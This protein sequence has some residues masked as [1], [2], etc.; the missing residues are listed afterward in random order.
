MYKTNV[1]DKVNAFECQKCNLT[2]GDRTSYV[3]HH[4]SYHEMSAKRCRTGKFGEPVIGIDGKFECPICRKTFEEKPQYFGHVGSHA[5]YEGLTPEAFLDKATSRR[6]TNDSSALTFGDQTSYAQHHLSYHEM[7]AKRCRTGKFGEPVVRID[8]KFECPICRKTFEEKPQ[9]FGHVGS[10]ARY[11]GLTP[12]AFLD[13]ATS[14]RATNDSSAEISFSL[15][16]LTESHGQNKVSYGEAGFQHHNHSN[17][18][19]ENN[20]TITEF[21]SRNYSDNFIRPNKTW[22]R[23]EVGPSFNDAPSV[24]RYTNFTGHADVTVPERAS[25][26]NN[27]SVSNINGFVGMAMFSD[28]R[29]SNH[30]VRP[31]AFGTANHYQDQIIDRGRAAPRHADNNTVIAR[32]VN[33][34]S[35]VNTISFP[36]ANA[37]NETSAAL[38]EAN[39]SSSTAMF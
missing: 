32:D 25:I 36:I 1:Q 28:Q 34:N 37:N 14:R 20:S 39:R 38:N 35:C 16:E 31:T 33:L 24:C 26:S 8:G 7:S 27:Q 9:Y 4:L 18:H 30:V 22:S 19:G 11:E 29:G 2:F 21:F 10:H 15:Q 23:P 12:E 17:T 6:A 5:R 13:K 3:Q